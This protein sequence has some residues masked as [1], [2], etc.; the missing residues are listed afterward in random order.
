[1]SRKRMPAQPERDY[2]KYMEYK[3]FHATLNRVDFEN[4]TFLFEI[5]DADEELIFEGVSFS[6]LKSE[7]RRLVDEY[8]ARGGEPKYYPG[9]FLFRITPELQHHADVAARQAG[10]SLNEW[11]MRTV[12]SALT[13]R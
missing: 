6:R 11:L 10:M 3:G 1:M 8:I 5:V 13:K 12:T 7:M 2:P 9:R 4:E